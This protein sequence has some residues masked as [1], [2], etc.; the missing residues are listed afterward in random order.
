ME[1]LT[2]TG[3]GSLLQTAAFVGLPFDMMSFTTLNERFAVQAGVA[4]G[5]GEYPKL[6]YYAIGIGGH[7]NSTGADGFPLNDPVQHTAED[8]GPYKPLPFVLRE[9]G[10]D[11]TAAERAKYALRRVET[12]N[13]RRY[14]AYYLKR[15]DKT[16]SVAKVERVIVDGETTTTAPWVPDN[17]NLYPTP[18][19]LSPDGV[20]TVNGSYLSVTAQLNLSLS[21]DEVSEIRAAALIMYND[22]RYATI[23]EVLLC[24]GLDRVVDSPSTG[25]S[26]IKQNEAICV[27]IVSHVNTIY[28]LK[29]SP[30][31]V[32]IILDCGTS[33][34][35][36]RITN[37]QMSSPVPSNP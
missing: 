29:F 13:N 28:P 11:L 8:T 25:N 18:P 2:R 9:E 31:G 3:A 32:D 27:Q 22:E 30:Q 34:P 4:P 21:A 17:S 37:V 20:N 19:L 1:N 23:S 5:V 15:I 36:F 35:L 16:G 7:K 24:S 6:G 12:H 26:T 10:N 33:E 14:Y